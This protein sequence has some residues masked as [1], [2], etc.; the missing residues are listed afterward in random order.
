MSNDEEI[1]ER[2]S[3]ECFQRLQE[4][5]GD[6]SAIDESSRTIAIVYSV[7]G[8]ID[9][10]GLSYLFEN[11]WPGQPPYTL[12][13]DAYR[14]IGQAAQA[15]AIA[16]AVR[17]FPFEEPEKHHA[18]RMAFLASEEADRLVAIEEGDS[19][20]IWDAL[21]DFARSHDGVG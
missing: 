9:N 16:A 15:E 7:Q 13:V 17:C 5:G 1:L 12:F 21:A 18:R 4:A 10:G 8:V 20:A 14:A 19:D 6:L 11:D 3:D 2:V